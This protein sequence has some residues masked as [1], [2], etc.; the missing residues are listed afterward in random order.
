MEYYLGRFVLELISFFKDFTKTLI[1]LS[2]TI[3]FFGYREQKDVAISLFKKQKNNLF[4]PYLIFL[5]LTL[6]LFITTIYLTPDLSNPLSWKNVFC[7]VIDISWLVCAITSYNKI[8][9]AINIRKTFDKSLSKIDKGFK[10]VD[11]I[12][13]D[14]DKNKKNS[15]RMARNIEKEVT[16]ISINAE[17]AFQ[18]LLSKKKYNLNNDFSYSIKILEKV[19]IAKIARINNESSYFSFIVPFSGNEYKKLFSITQKGIIDLMDVALGM[20]NPKDTRLL[21]DN[22]SSIRPS[23]FKIDSDID[24]FWRVHAKSSI[25]L[26]THFTQ[27][28]DDFYLSSFRIINKLY[29]ENNNRAIFIL[30]YL[31]KYNKHTFSENDL[32]TLIASLTNNSIENNDLKQLTDITNVLFDYLEERKTTTGHTLQLKNKRIN[33]KVI[34]SKIEHLFESNQRKIYRFSFLSIVKAIELGRYSCAGFL[35]KNTVKNFDQEMYIKEVFGIL[36]N[37][38]NIEPNLELSKNLTRLLPI[39]FTFSKASY[40]YCI[41]K[42]VLLLHYQQVYSNIVKINNIEEGKV[43]DIEKLFGSKIDYLSYLNEKI[44]GLHKEYGLIFLEEEN[45]K[46]VKK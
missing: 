35:I 4:N 19:L 20:N 23:T 37:V 16:E 39:N 41:F 11:R 2:F 10:E 29:K 15:R 3:Y 1:P 42:S 33:A 46:K 25:S 30:R 34:N 22:F 28:Y 40:E 45:F 21:I 36:K 43:I 17:I 12:K 31:V 26:T 18:I 38:D 14:Y 7:F 27:M 5:A 13:K 8:L 32:L 44:E 9:N 6:I 24:L